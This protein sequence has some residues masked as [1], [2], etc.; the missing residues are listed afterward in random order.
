MHHKQ[1]HSLPEDRRELA[2]LARRLDFADAD[3]FLDYYNR[4]R[5]SVRA[6]YRNYLEGK[7]PPTARLNRW[8]RP[9][10]PPLHMEASY[11]ETFT[12]ADRARHL[13][14]LARLSDAA[15]VDVAAAPVADG[16]WQVTVVGFNHPGELAII[17]GLLFAWGCN[18]VDGNAFSEENVSGAAA[19][20]SSA[21]R[22]RTQGATAD[23]RPP[24]SSTSSPSSRRPR[25][26][27]ADIVDSGKT[28]R[29]NWP[30]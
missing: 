9:R 10:P 27:P 8:R 14:L 25:C 11:V 30:T 13:E 16:R 12:S 20:A 24:S 3:Q 23:A 21:A 4:H 26:R 5:A 6:I 7:T 22:R 17:C 2:F 28:T 19:R 1:T 29:A 15:P 18:I